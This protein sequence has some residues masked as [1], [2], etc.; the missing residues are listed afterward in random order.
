ML[1]VLPCSCSLRLE[2]RSKEAEGRAASA[3]AENRTSTAW[4]RGGAW[5]RP[6]RVPAGDTTTLLTTEPLVGSRLLFILVHPSS[7]DTCV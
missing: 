7:F 3:G 1:A 4:P 2:L 5:R 6:G